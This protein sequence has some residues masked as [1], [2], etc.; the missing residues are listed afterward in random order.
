MA[1]QTLSS[2]SEHDSALNEKTKQVPTAETAEGPNVTFH[3]FETSAK[4]ITTARGNITLTWDPLT[5]DEAE[6]FIKTSPTRD[7]RQNFAKSRFRVLVV[8]YANLKYLY[9][10]S[11]VLAAAKSKGW[12]TKGFETYMKNNT[13]GS[14]VQEVGDSLNFMAQSPHDDKFP[15]FSLCLSS[16]HDTGYENTPDWTALIFLGPSNPKAHNK[17][18]LAEL[19]DM[20]TREPYPNDFTPPL[21]PDLMILPVALLR[22]QVDNITAG[23]AK[24]KR[25]IGKADEDMLNSHRVDMKYLRRIKLQLFE[26]R[27]RQ[28]MLHQRYVFSKEL[29]AN[30]E[31]AFEKLKKRA[32]G[33]PEEPPVEYSELLK[34][35]VESQKFNLET[36][37]YDIKTMPERIEA[38]QTMMDGQTGILIARN[39]D[40]AAEEARRDSAS[41]K[42]IAIVTLVFLPGTFVAAIFSMSM[43]QW[44]PDNED[45]SSSNDAKQSGDDFKILSD[46]FWLYWAVTVPLTLIILVV[47]YIW[48]KWSNNKYKEKREKELDEE[49][50]IE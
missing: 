35:A 41:M 24:L 38:Q 40:S 29:G 49:V 34:E 6:K 48:Y 5:E 26:L 28:G 1:T 46:W 4:R 14:A 45:S 39:S 22:W 7:N 9:D 17:L 50:K 36:L 23:I 16:H 32:G 47:W 3:K 31:R 8:Q 37:K 13:T 19:K 12:I 18:D 21:S 44:L 20:L 27:R 15:F 42:T 10:H 2:N 11:A 33:E 30:L 25:D 43:F